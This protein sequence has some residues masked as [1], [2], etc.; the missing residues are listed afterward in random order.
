MAFCLRFRGLLPAADLS[1]PWSSSPLDVP[2]PWLAPCSSSSGLDPC[3]GTGPARPADS[4]EPGE[5][6]LL[7][8]LLLGF[9]HPE[10]KPQMSERL[11]VHQPPVSREQPQRRDAGLGEETPD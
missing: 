9:V 11:R 10:L 7:G 2:S 8:G 3:S 4:V 6:A 5:A 1:P